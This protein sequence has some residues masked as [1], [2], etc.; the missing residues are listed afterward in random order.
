MKKCG[1]YGFRKVNF[2]IPNIFLYLLYMCA[3][4]KLKVNFTKK[5]TIINILFLI[6]GTEISA[7]FSF[8]P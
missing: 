1:G 6:K 3:Y 2:K 5:Y 8:L 4:S 7:I